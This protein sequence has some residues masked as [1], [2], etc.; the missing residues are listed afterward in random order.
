MSYE[1]RKKSQQNKSE[2]IDTSKGFAQ[3]DRSLFFSVQFYNLSPKA[4]RAYSNL[5][6]LYEP[7]KSDEIKASLTKL[8]MKMSRGSWF[9]GIKELEDTGFI[10]VTRSTWVGAGKGRQT[11]TYKLSNDWKRKPC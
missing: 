9:Y 4:Q 5:R 6:L 3:F 8:P 1:K 11:N 7:H 10:I 2:F